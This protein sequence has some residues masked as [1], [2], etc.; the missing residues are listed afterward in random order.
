[1]KIFDV[2]LLVV[3]AFGMSAGQVLFKLSSASVQRSLELSTLINLC[4]NAYFIAAVIVYALMTLLWV[5]ILS[6]IPLSVAYPFS[7]LAIIFTTLFSIVFL[8][9]SISVDFVIGM[10]LLLAGLFFIARHMAR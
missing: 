7:G 1:M 3:F 8:R 10:I 9:E 6:T 5:W 4:S 2:V